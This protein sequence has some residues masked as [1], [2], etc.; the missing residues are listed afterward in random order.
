MLIAYYFILMDGY[1]SL[2]IFLYCHV[3]ITIRIHN[4]LTIK[5][6]LKWM[7]RVRLLLLL[8]ILNGY[9]EW[10]YFFERVGIG[11]NECFEW[12]YLFDKVFIG[13]LLQYNRLQKCL[14]NMLSKMFMQNQQIKRHMT[15]SCKLRKMSKRIEEWRWKCY[16]LHTPSHGWK[17]TPKSS[18][19]NYH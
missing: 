7:L 9:F 2:L 19:N 17:H 11:L 15:I 8:A 6:I 14:T 5:E 3:Y 18:N 10:A 16:V 13:T 4:A 1:E 12:K